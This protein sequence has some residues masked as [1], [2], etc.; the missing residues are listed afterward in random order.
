MTHPIE[1]TFMIPRNSITRIW[2]LALGLA[3]LGWV[4]P[5]AK[6][7]AINYTTVGTVFAPTSGTSGLVFYNGVFNSSLAS[8]G[9]PIDLGQFV[10]T[11]SASTSNATFTN[12]PFNIIV[13]STNNAA[14]MI[15]GVLNGSIATSATSTPLTATFTSVAQYGNSGLPFNIELPLNTP[16][17]LNMSNGSAP[18]STIL[19]GATSP[20][21][22]IP[23]PTSI[24]IFGLA[25]GGLAIYRR[26]ALRASIA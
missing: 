13:T 10:M 23:E 15:T 3:L 11:P 24:A 6:A 5:E 1:R 9:S 12:T 8:A 20:I 18:A 26:R 2:A 19:S 7:D 16:F 21:T 22:P 4:A 25:L 14:D 17:N